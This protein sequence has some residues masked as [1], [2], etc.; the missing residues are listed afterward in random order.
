M[1]KEKV[2]VSSSPDVK[3]WV[4]EV[5]KAK[6][7]GN[8]ADDN[9]L[10]AALGAGNVADLVA[11]RFCWDRKAATAAAAAVPNVNG[12]IH[13]S[14]ADDVPEVEEITEEEAT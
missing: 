6:S 12:H 2:S 5:V 10:R 1:L 14:L 11:D 13:C 3:G 7:N 4:D 8:L 9:K